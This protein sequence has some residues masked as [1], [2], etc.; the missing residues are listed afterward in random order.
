MIK[1]QISSFSSTP[2]PRNFFNIDSIMAAVT[3]MNEQIAYH[4]TE[5]ARL[6][7]IRLE[8]QTSLSPFYRIPEET[9]ECIFEY[10]VE[11]NSFGWRPGHCSSDTYK[12]GQ[13]CRRWRNLSQTTSRLWTTILLKIH[14]FRTYPITAFQRLTDHLLRSQDSPLSVEIEIE[15]MVIEHDSST[16]FLDLVLQQS[17]RW[18]SFHYIQLSQIGDFLYLDFILKREMR[19]LETLK[20]VLDQSY[21]QEVPPE[22]TPCIVSSSL[23]TVH[24]SFS[25]TAIMPFLG[26]F[27]HTPL[28]TRLRVE[29]D[30][31]DAIPLLRSCQNLVAAHL[32]LA[33]TGRPIEVHSSMIPDTHGT[34]HTLTVE[35]PSQSDLHLISFFLCAFTSPWLTSLSVITTNLS[36]EQPVV[37]SLLFSNSLISFLR[38]SGGPK[39]LKSFK[40]V[41]IP[42][43]TTHLIQVLHVLP[44]LR[45]LE[46]HSITNDGFPPL[47]TTAFFHALNFWPTASHESSVYPRKTVA[48]PM[49]R[50]ANFIVGNDWEDNAFE[51]MLQSRVDG[52]LKSVFLRIR[53]RATHLDVR[54]LESINAKSDLAVRV[55]EGESVEK[56]VV[57]YWVKPVVGLRRYCWRD[58]ISLSE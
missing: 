1:Q 53:G 36:Y 54:W 29:V 5:L 56:E 2:G 30:I 24:L 17:H 22:L 3:S 38:R 13:V 10:A 23:Q 21:D 34:L 50:E 20:V 43:P 45:T 48:L 14:P 7:R 16:R 25:G 41:E 35:A 8:Y 15:F 18:R 9:L 19:A 47:L 11:K 31:R 58:L 28:L 27:G 57:G 42:I 51:N 39:T 37:L 4:K 55:V 44:S 12:L 6:K 52:E 32:V 46:I 26:I 40:V 33:N 49:L